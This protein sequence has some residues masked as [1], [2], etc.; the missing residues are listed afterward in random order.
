MIKKRFLSIVLSLSIIA[1][2]AISPVYATDTN[3]SQKNLNEKKPVTTITKYSTEQ[4]KASTLSDLGVNTNK[5]TDMTPLGT[6][7]SE[8]PVSYT[9]SYTQVNKTA[10]HIAGISV[11]TNGYPGTYTSMD[12]TYTGGQSVEWVVGGAVEG[13]AEFNLFALDASAKLS[14]SVSRASTVS[15][16]ISV[17]LPVS[18]K[19][20]E[21]ATVNIYAWGVRTGGAMKYYWQDI[22]G[23][24]GYVTKSV[25]SSLPYKEY[26]GTFIH[27]GAPV[28]E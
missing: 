23:A 14:A 26:K 12:I 2:S 24:S 8:W 3:S 17:T 25:S 11:D 1:C 19:T 5:T 27:F 22:S 16:S 15:S 28:Y 4:I 13:E 21:V 18:I 10:F 6:M 20:N 9:S 7:Y